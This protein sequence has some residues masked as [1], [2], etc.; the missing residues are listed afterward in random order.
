VTEDRG[1]LR[2]G[3]DPNRVSN[4]FDGNTGKPVQFS[5]QIELDRN[6]NF[7]SVVD[8]FDVDLIDPEIVER[9]EKCKTRLG[10]FQSLAKGWHNGGG[11]PIAPEAIRAAEAF[12]AKRPAFAETYGIFPTLDGGVL[13]EFQTK[14]WDFSLEVG[15]T[16]AIEIFGIEIDGPGELPSHVYERLD[17]KFLAEFDRH[18]GVPISQ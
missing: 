8:V 9:L 17:D 7:R 6:E 15:K 1:E 16:G 2:V 14:T 11:E 3:M 12:L 10:E 13:I 5:L 4:E 18:I